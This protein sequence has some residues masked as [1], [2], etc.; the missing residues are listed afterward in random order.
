MISATGRSG[1][2]IIR[3]LPGIYIAQR[4]ALISHLHDM[5]Q[6]EYGPMMRS[7]H[8]ELSISQ[9]HVGEGGVY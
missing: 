3:K 6:D 7:Y 1:S 4:S 8:M 2:G 5:E 9:G